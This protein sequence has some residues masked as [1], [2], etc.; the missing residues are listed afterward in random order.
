M[1]QSPPAR[2]TQIYLVRAGGL[3][4]MS[5]DFQSQDHPGSNL[6][7]FDLIFPHVGAELVIVELDHQ[8]K[9]GTDRATLPFRSDFIDRPLLV[10]NIDSLTAIFGVMINNYR[11]TDTNSI[12]YLHVLKIPIFLIVRF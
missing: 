3:R 2:T 10:L 7:R 8:G 5:R 11:C 1:M 4:I 12:A 9:I 6:D